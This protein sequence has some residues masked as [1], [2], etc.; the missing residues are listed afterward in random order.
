LN[1][2]HGVN[3]NSKVRVYDYTQAKWSFKSVLVSEG[4]SDNGPD[5]HETFKA[6]DDDRA[7]N[8]ATANADSAER[9]LGGGRILIDGH[10]MAMAQALVNLSGARDGVDGTYRIRQARHVFERGS[11]WTTSLEVEQP[12]GDAGE[13]TR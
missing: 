1:Y 3:K 5:L 8:R 10:P 12:S 4:A 2:S 7:G 9:A 6:A 11:G 13:D